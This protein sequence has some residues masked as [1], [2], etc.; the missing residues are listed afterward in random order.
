MSSSK[1]FHFFW[2]GPFS[3][4]HKSKFTLQGETF[5]TAEQYMMYQKAL[6]FNDKVNAANIIATEDP[7]EQ[8]GF[9]RQVANFDTKIWEQHRE[10]IVYTGNLAKFSQD[11]E[12]LALI[13]DDKYK[14]VEFVEASPYDT[15]WGI[16]LREED[17]DAQDKNK[18]IISQVRDDLRKQHKSKQ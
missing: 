12:L 8:K 9:G 15:I 5:V 14:D 17:P 4:W 10:K 6:L 16:G 18:W 7:K 13:L 1:K 2:A 3:Q 11:K